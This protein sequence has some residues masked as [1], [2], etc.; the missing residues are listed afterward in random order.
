MA[1]KLRHKIV[2]LAIFSALLPVVVM[3]VLTFI[4]KVNLKRAIDHEMNFM[5]N[6]NISSS[7]IDVLKACEIAHEI[8][9][10]SIVLDVKAF[11]ALLNE[12]G[13]IGFNDSER[14]DWNAVNQ[15]TKNVVRVELPAVTLGKRNIE[16]SDDMGREVPVIDRLRGFTG[17]TYTIFQR[18]N[19]AGDMLRVATNVQTD[20]GKRAVGTYIPAVNPDGKANA[21]VSSLLRGELYSGTAYVVN[22][23]YITAYKPL[24]D[25]TGQVVGC[26]YAGV[27]VSSMEM[28]KRKLRDIKLGQTG[29]VAILEGKG[30][31]RGRYVVSKDGARDGENIINEKDADGK[32][33]IQN[34]IDSAINNPGKI[35]FF[36][37][38]WKNP[39]DRF[40][41]PKK[42]VSIYF[43]PWNWVIIPTVYLDDY[44]EMSR[45]VDRTIN[46]LLFT[47]IL[48]GILFLV[49]AAGVAWMVSTRISG[50]V[51]RVSDIAGLIASGDIGAAVAGFGN[52]SRAVSARGEIT[53]RLLPRDET[54]SLVRS[55]VLMTRNLNSLVSEVQKATINLVSTSTEIAASAREQEVTVNEL[56]SSANEIVSSTKEISSTSQQLVNTM[57]EVSE[58]SN[59]T[60]G[61]AEAGRHGLERMEHSMEQ[62]ALATTSIA[63]KLSLINEKTGNINN[64][65]ATITKVA[66]QTNLLSLNASI[67]AEKAGE[68]GKGFAVVAREI[69]RLADQTAVATLDIIK[70]V[71]DMESAVSS[72]VMGME[73]FSGD[74]RQSVKDTEQIS[75]QIEGVIREVQRLPEKFDMVIDG[76]KQQAVGAQQISDSMVQLNECAHS[77]SDSLRAFNEAAE[78]L[79]RAT[80]NLQKE[81]TSFKVR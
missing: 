67:E 59:N 53:D 25:K 12:G 61:L 11:E 71:G 22:D 75:D 35:T 58:V 81:M 33:L 68:Y 21:V 44:S 52:L 73:K 39:D 18:M 74:V 78:Q 23:L 10:D 63:A 60:A 49:I 24:K 43:E 46:N 55:V 40:A 76:M 20:E 57:K 41:R 4:Q 1:L 2:I 56:S 66:D 6:D 3:S 45:Q 51:S 34:M 64:V 29:Y 27:K 19:D 26:I 38:M 16:V 69:R 14:V 36:N 70:M 54:G 15:F 30:A 42:G 7:A 5:A 80:L 8:L 13:G 72:G 17:V 50:P 65:V 32:P 31:G 28:V 37:Y 77:T 47:I 9:R 79:N 62:L 48:G